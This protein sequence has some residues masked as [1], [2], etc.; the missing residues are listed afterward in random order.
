MA[1]EAGSLKASREQF[2]EER[3]TDAKVEVLRTELARACRTIERQEA[4]IGA[5]L[6]HYHGDRGNLLVPLGL[7]GAAN[8]ASEALGGAFTI[9]R[10]I[11]FSLRTER[12]RR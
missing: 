11:P 4:Q 1:A 12:E 9:D 3:S 2:W 7:H 8:Q 6:Q 5:L 10:G